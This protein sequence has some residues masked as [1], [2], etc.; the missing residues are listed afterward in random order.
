MRV[1]GPRMGVNSVAEA[2]CLISD[3]PLQQ[4]HIPPNTVLLANAPQYAHLTETVPFD[5]G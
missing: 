2:G 5:K 3:A 4:D 1:L